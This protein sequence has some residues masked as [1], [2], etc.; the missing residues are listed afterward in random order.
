MSQQVRK[1]EIRRRRQRREKRLRQRK[2][3][4]IAGLPAASKSPTS[5]SP[6]GSPE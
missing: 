3:A 5:F 1:K 4:L 2:A 6:I